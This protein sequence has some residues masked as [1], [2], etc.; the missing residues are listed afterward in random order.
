M[1]PVTPGR[2]PVP[3]TPAVAV[4][5]LDA[6]LPVV[7]RGRTL[8]EVRWR[9]PTPLT[10]LIP[11]DG[12]RAGA[13]PDPYLL[14]LGFSHYPDWPPSTQFV[15]PSTSSYEFPVDARHLPRIEGTNEISIH[16]QYGSP[17][18]QLVCSSVT[19]EFY[20]V[21]HGVEQR[22][23]WDPDVHTFAATLNA[24]R[25]GLRPPFYK[26]PQAT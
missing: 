8:D 25:H 26:G 2:P 4:A 7:L 1:A 21:G 3:T 6:H 17:P 12:T 22:H 20:A 5:A 10:L 16:A 19:L 9:R 18:I 14:R 23:L 11:V 24:V 15:N 13:P